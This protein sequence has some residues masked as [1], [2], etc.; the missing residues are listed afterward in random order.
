MR[1]DTS[2]HILC[3]LLSPTK[4]PSFKIIAN[5]VSVLDRMQL[6]LDLH[7]EEKRNIK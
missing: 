3:P 1:N 7:K 6:F 5:S 4:V 2:R